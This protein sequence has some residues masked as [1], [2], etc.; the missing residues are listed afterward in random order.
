M[1]RSGTRWGKAVAG[2]AGLIVLIAIAP[3]G[4]ARL[5]ASPVPADCGTPVSSWGGGIADDVAID[6]IAVE[7]NEAPASTTPAATPAASAPTFFAELR[8]ENLG[9]TAASIV[10][11]EITLI[12]CDGDQVTAL[13]APDRPPFPDGELPAGA[14]VTGWVGFALGADDAP[15][16]LVVPVAR[17]GLTGGR[18]EFPLVDDTGIGTAG[19]AGADAIGGDAVGADGA[20]GADA[21]A[22]AGDSREG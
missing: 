11:A 5:Q 22:A 20:D 6:L 18:V 10:V 19:A 3:A 13:P 16:R 9:D 17:P 15:V 1:S 2:L 12:L 4:A 14:P 8:A 7:W 21:T